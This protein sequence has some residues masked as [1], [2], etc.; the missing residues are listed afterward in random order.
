MEQ[1]GA[2]FKEKAKLS[3]EKASKKKNA[4]FCKSCLVYRIVLKL[5]QSA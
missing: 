2:K 3:S 1:N 4:G 5:P